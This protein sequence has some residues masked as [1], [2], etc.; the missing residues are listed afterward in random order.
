[1]VF[2]AK[3]MKKS[4][5]KKKKFTESAINKNELATEIEKI[6]VGLYYLSETDA[7]IVL[8]CGNKAGSVTVEEILEQTDNA[9]E[10]AVEERDFNEFFARL[11]II[12]DWF[13]DEE[14]KNANRFAEL[15][16]LLED[17]LRD[18]RVFKIGKINLDIYVV[19]LNAESNLMGIKTK[20]VET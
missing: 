11:T 1:M 20:A 16:K 6:V 19:G 2:E 18:I 12:Q 8:F 7:E 15:K 14:T 5:K 9:A 17:N 13:G 4:R 10:T 3:L